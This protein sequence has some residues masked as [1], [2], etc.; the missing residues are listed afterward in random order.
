MS[1]Y[2]VKVTHLYGDTY[3]VEAYPSA[4][5]VLLPLV[6]LFGIGFV[7]H[8]MQKYDLTFEQAMRLITAGI[9]GLGFL[10]IGLIFWLKPKFDRFING[11]R[12]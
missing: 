11:N 6:A 4:R 12:W 10:A 8:L 2:D 1:E 9:L 7:V 3:R 5:S